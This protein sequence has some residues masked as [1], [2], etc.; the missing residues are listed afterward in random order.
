M[1]KWD[2]DKSSMVNYRTH[3][4]LEN[5]TEGTENIMKMCIMAFPSL[6]VSCMSVLNYA[7]LNKFC[8][9]VSGLFIL[10]YLCYEFLNI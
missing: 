6:W 8:H 5:G 4:A 9:L 2:V 7:L 3:L 10:D 1:C